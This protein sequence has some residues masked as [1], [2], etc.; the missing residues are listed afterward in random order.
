CALD[1]G[2][3][4]VARLAAETDA[5][6]AGRVEDDLQPEAVRLHRLRLLDTVAGDVRRVVEPR[7]QRGVGGD[8]R[9]DFAHARL[10]ARPGQRLLGGARQLGKLTHVSAWGRC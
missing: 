3:R 6:T 8:E 4:Q 10:R 1:T 2:E 9:L 5:R 7:Q